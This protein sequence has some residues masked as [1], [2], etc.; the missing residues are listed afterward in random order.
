MGLGGV[1]LHTERR[2][3]QQNGHVDAG[4]HRV[5]SVRSPACFRY[6]E[7]ASDSSPG[8]AG[9]AKLDELDGKRLVL[10]TRE[11]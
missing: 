6:F 10:F 5:N 1:H 4:P 11:L 2:A 9:F 8:L 3:E 7:C